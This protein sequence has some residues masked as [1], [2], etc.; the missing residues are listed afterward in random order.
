MFA[1]PN[2]HPKACF[3]AWAAIKGKILTEDFFKRRNICLASRYSLCQENEETGDCR[4]VLCPWV[5]S[6]SN[7]VWSLFGTC[8]LLGAAMKDQRCLGSMKEE[9]EEGLDF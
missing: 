3:F 5:L 1:R 9:D 8:C 6:L 7:L 2:G 4:L